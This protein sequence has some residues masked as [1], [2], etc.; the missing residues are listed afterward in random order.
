MQGDKLS[1]EHSA[2]KGFPGSEITKQG[3]VWHI[4]IKNPAFNVVKSNN[5]IASPV[6]IR[7]VRDL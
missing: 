1:G 7:V 4:R 5:G 2:S 6:V 3:K